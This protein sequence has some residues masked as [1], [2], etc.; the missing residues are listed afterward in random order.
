M[1][2]IHHPMIHIKAE[3]FWLAACWW[4]GPI[5]KAIARAYPP[6]T[7][8]VNLASAITK[9]SHLHAFTEDLVEEIVSDFLARS[10]PWNPGEP[11]Q[12]Y[13]MRRIGIEGAF[14]S[15]PLKVSMRRFGLEE[16]IPYLEDGCVSTICPGKVFVSWNRRDRETVLEVGKHATEQRP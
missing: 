8:F 1:P 6:E 3:E 13:R 15:E 2:T 14:R 12:G 10:V 4:I 5:K 16:V 7:L 9:E 11:M